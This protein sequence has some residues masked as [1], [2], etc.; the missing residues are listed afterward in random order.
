MAMYVDSPLDTW[1]L[2]NPQP[3]RRFKFLTKSI[4]KPSWRILQSVLLCGVVNIGGK[5]GRDFMLVYYKV[6]AIVDDNGVCNIPH[7]PDLRLR[8]IMH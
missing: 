3:P 6:Y 2:F 7:V 8:P 4:I 1:D 5:K